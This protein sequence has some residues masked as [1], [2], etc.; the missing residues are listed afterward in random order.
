MAAWEAMAG[1][2][3][4]PNILWLAYMAMTSVAGK[5]RKGETPA[6]C[7]HIRSLLRLRQP[8]R[9]MLPG[10][11]VTLALKACWICVIT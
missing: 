4:D 8:S 10:R 2:M 6:M 3:G 1:H 7:R 5:T 11:W 9:T